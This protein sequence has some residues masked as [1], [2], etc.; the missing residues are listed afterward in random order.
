MVS[1][2][3]LLTAPCDIKQQWMDNG[4]NHLS[5]LDVL[6][7]FWFKARPEPYTSVCVH[8]SPF[9]SHRGPGRYSFPEYKLHCL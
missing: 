7:S 6:Q 3:F 1:F 9:S 2:F 5:L 8:L 4:L